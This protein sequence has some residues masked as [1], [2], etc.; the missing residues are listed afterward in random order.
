LVFVFILFSDR[1]VWCLRFFAQNGVA[2]FACWAAIRFVLTFNI[3]LQVHC[4]L[5]VVNAGTIC[6][7]LAAVFAGGF[8]LGTNFNATLVER[9]AY[10]FSPWV[11]FIIF[12]WGVVE[13]NWIP[14]NIT[15][16][17][18]IAGIELL[19][20]LVS[21]VFALALFTMRHRASKIDPIV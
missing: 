2:F 6:L 14:K 12:F 5:S 1:D 7:S 20:S 19:A 8:F 9:C 16:N 10:Q 3:F 18:I 21:A 17:N 13:N 4:N 11:I 15:R